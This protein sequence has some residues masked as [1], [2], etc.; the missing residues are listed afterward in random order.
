M[1]PLILLARRLR[2]AGCEVE[3]FLGFRDEERVYGVRELEKYGA[4]RLSVGGAVTDAVRERLSGGLP[5][6]IL[7]CGPTPMMKAVQTLCTE[8][9][10]E[11]RA[12]LE[13]YMGC[14]LG[15]CLVCNCKVKAKSGF[16]YKRVCAD[17]PVFDLR[18]V[19]FNA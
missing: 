17:G 2:E 7:T 4:A 18:E 14:G 19:V 3:S 9:G 11:A 5:D 12:S 15:A 8:R 1:A 6:L 13:E 16:A 10:I